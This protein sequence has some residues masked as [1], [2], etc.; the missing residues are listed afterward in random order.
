MFEEGDKVLL[1]NLKTKKWDIEGIVQKVQI[2]EDGTILSYEVK[3]EDLELW[4]SQL[5]KKRQ[6]RNQNPGW[7]T[8]VKLGKVQSQEMS[9]KG[10]IFLIIYSIISTIIM[11]IMI[12]FLSQKCYID[13]TVAGDTNV[14]QNQ[15][16]YD[17][18]SDDRE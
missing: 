8:S 9:N 4:K 6:S 10:T 11:G 2:A 15:N 13:S 16:K 18:L 3:I 12:Y 7:L 1:Q 17:I 5:R 14:V